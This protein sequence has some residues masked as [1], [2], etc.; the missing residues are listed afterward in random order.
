MLTFTWK[1]LEKSWRSR[2]FVTATPTV[3]GATMRCVKS[4]SFK[5][6]I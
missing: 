2:F 4:T 3:L 5:S 1:A 6:K